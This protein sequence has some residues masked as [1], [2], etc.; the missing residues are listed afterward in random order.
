MS[1]C[2]AATSLIEQD[3]KAV[4]KELF[5]QELAALSRR[6]TQLFKS[7]AEF[8]ARH[9]SLTKSEFKEEFTKIGRESVQIL[10]DSLLPAETVRG[11]YMKMLNPR[12]PKKRG[13]KR[14]YDTESDERIYAAWKTGNYPKYADLARDMRIPESEVSQAIDRQ[15]HRPCS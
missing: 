15:R 11:A 9:Q 12:L 13:R 8:R 2:G 1:R 3:L 4:R 5:S 10:K 7:I 6:L 14:K